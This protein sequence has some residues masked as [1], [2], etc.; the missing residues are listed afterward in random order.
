MG[1]C[2]LVFEDGKELDGVWGGTYA[3]FG[4]FRNAIVTSL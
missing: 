2:L 1:R 4:D 3:D